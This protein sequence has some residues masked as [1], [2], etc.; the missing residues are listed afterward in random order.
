[1]K[2]ITTILILKLVFAL[3][4]YGDEFLSS[5][6]FSVSAIGTSFRIPDSWYKQNREEWIGTIGRLD[7]S[8]EDIAALLESREGAVYIAS[9]L[10]YDPSTRSGSIPAINMSLR[11]YSFSSPTI[12][13]RYIEKVV[14]NQSR[15][16]NN[17]EIVKYPELYVVSGKLAVRYKFQYDLHTSETGK[18]AIVTE[19]YALPFDSAFL[20]VILAEEIPA[21][22]EA[23]FK[24]MIQS[25]EF[26]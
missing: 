10:K 2:A 23:L 26:K 24:M 11:K 20:S 21:Q 8:K 22:H 4:S 25:F 3:T 12:F 14:E 16:F 1:M 19:G 15:V 5:E 17:F 18:S 9:L 13:L 6:E 7:E